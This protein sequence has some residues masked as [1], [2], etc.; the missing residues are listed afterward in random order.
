MISGD[1]VRLLGDSVAMTWMPCLVEPG[2]GSE[3]PLVRLEH[4]PVDRYPAFVAARGRP[5]TVPAYGYGLTV[6]AR[7]SAKIRPR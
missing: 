6:F 4:P 3:V 2:A 1:L 7:S 5:N